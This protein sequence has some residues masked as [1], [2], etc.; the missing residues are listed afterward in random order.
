MIDTAF[1]RVKREVDKEG[2]LS[3]Y[4]RGEVNDA[5]LREA[6]IRVVQE[7]SFFVEPKLETA[8]G[9]ITTAA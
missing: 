6:G 5:S 9:K 2:L 8:A 3:T 4:A 1:I 7:E